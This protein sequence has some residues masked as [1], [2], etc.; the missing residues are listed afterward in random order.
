MLVSSCYVVQRPMLVVNNQFPGPLIEA[1]QGD[2]IIVNVINKTPS[3]D[4][5]IHW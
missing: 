5:T 2:T 3:S 4:I 1:N